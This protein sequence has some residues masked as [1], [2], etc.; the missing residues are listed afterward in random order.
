M[1]KRAARPKEKEGIGRRDGAPPGGDRG[2][3]S[4]R[5]LPAFRF[6][7]GS[8]GSLFEV[9]RPSGTLFATALGT[10]AGEV[11]AAPGALA[12]EVA[13]TSARAARRAAAKLEG[14]FLLEFGLPCSRM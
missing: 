10:L 9:R 2:A 3:R 7:V 11:E 4:P 6:R 1:S 5:C 14:D 8:K 12:G 13:S